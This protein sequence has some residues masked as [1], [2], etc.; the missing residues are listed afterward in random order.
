ELGAVL[1]PRLPY[2]AA[3]IVWAVRE[4]LA[5]TLDDVLS[6]RT[7]ALFLDA[8]ASMEIAPKVAELMAAELRLDEGW[9]RAEVERFLTHARGYLLGPAPKPAVAAAQGS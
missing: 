1:H 8:R 9:Q 7:R 4:E 5:R 3:E 2:L 6:R